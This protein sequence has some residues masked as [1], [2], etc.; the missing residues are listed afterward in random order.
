MLQY[1][2]IMVS[3]LTPPLGLMEHIGAFWHRPEIRGMPRLGTH[4]YGLPPLEGLVWTSLAGLPQVK[5]GDGASNWFLA[6]PGG[7]RPDIKIALNAGAVNNVI[8]CGA[9]AN[10]TGTT[11]FQ[12]TDG[13]AI[14]AGPSDYDESPIDVRLS[15]PQNTFFLGTRVRS[16]EVDVIIEGAGMHACI[17]ED[18]MLAA[19]LAIRT[20]DLHG[21]VDMNSGAWVNRPAPV[22]IEPRVWLGN[23]AL[24]LK[25]TQIGF[26]SIVGAKAV[27]RGIVARYGCVAGVPARI[28]RENVSW[29]FFRSPSEGLVERLRA[30]EEKLMP[31]PVF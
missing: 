16:A 24:I 3:A 19:G 4:G 25:N 2:N 29:D 8:V 10:V 7:I 23:D 12:S 13:I 1:K 14:Y 6:P 18:C 31:F 27:V 21:I 5:S 15:S 30:Y 22:H 11:L 28:I 26:G 20:T 9:K 17:G